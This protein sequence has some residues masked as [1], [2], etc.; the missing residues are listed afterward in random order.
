VHDD[1]AKLSMSDRQ[2]RGFPHWPGW[3]YRTQD[4]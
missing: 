3:V 1:A 4:S 2:A